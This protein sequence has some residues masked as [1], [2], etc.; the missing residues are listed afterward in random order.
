MTCVQSYS[1]F[2]SPSKDRPLIKFTVRSTCHQKSGDA[3]H[4]SSG[5]ISSVSQAPLSFR[6]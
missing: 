6:D 3:Y 1:Y 2:T 5:R 4:I